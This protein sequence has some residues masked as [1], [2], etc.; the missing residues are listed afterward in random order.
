MDK[1]C[2]AGNWGLPAVN[3]AFLHLGLIPPLRERRCS[4]RRGRGHFK[5]LLVPFILCREGGHGVGRKKKKAGIDFAETEGG[6]DSPEGT[7]GHGGGY[8]QGE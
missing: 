5:A 1:V 7:W 4:G 2:L 6:M 3:P 8:R